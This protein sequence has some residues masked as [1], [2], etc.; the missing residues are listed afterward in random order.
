MFIVCNEI[1]FNNLEII[2]LCKVTSLHLS[3]HSVIHKE[4]YVYRNI[5]VDRG[6]LF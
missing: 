4:L 3:L 5:V 2:R 1:S 6:S